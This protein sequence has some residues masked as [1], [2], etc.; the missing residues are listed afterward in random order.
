MSSD[1]PTGWRRLDPARWTRRGVCLA[2][3]SP[4]IFGLI[5]LAV[6]AVLPE[7]QVWPHALKALLLAAPRNALALWPAVAAGLALRRRELWP[8]AVL[9]GGLGALLAGAP[10][11]GG[12]GQGYKLISA[13]VNTF[14]DDP[15]PAHAADVLAAEQADVVVV[16]ERR[17][18]QIPGMRR[19]ADDFEQPM[20]RQSHALAVFC[21]EGLDCAARV[22]PHIGSET[23]KM[24]VGLVRL[25]SDA[26][27]CLIAV[28]A[29]PPAP[30][31]PSGIVPYV[32]EVA[33]HLADGRLSQDWAPCQR[34]DAA[35]VAGDLN[36]VPYST[37]WRAL[38]ATGMDTPLVRHGVAANTWPSGGGWP[39]LPFFPLDHLFVGQ[40]DISGL[41]LL[42]VPGTD[43]KALVWW[44]AARRG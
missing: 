34:G 23:M 3:F 21:R 44:V 10:L 37:A 25:V 30:Y 26:P 12:V 4:A 29:P 15:D 40:A 33:A 18:E 27:L 24:P 41:R 38:Q 31:D 11:P 7:D 6:A 39:N 13:N 1:A 36:A 5:A 32:S 19:V 35:V 43:H 42:R 2:L 14:S 20:P 17:V 28:H 9:L 16:I 22:T 8:A